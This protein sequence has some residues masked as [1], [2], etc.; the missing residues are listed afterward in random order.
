MS[1][2][3]LVHISSIVDC[4]YEK[5]TTTP[6]LALKNMYF[7][8]SKQCLTTHQVRVEVMDVIENRVSS[9]TVQCYYEMVD[10]NT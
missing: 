10:F 6:I 4:A 7:F 2:R 3:T 9:H 8:I 1:L 5:H